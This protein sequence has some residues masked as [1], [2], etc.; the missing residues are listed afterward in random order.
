M[1]SIEAEQLDPAGDA[2]LLCKTSVTAAA[3]TLLRF[4]A[5]EAGARAAG[6]G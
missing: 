6:C 2:S 4:Q 3:Q 5:A 1:T